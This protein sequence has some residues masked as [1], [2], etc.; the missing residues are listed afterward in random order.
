MEG[1][2]STGP[3]PSSFNQQLMVIR[4]RFELVPISTKVVT[5]KCKKKLK[6]IHRLQVFGNMGKLQKQLC[7]ISEI[8]N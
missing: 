6:Q 1:L 4:S 2:L 3:T 8:H 5:M 7:T